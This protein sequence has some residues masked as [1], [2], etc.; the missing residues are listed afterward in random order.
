MPK[1][2]SVA[3]DTPG[4]IVLCELELPE[5]ATIAEALAAARGHLGADAGAGIDWERAAAGIYGRTYPREHV[6]ADGERIELYRPL[7]ADPRTRRRAR[8]SATR[9]RP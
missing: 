4:G 3:C 8:A 7:Q 9:R 1:R 2:C 6:P 5:G